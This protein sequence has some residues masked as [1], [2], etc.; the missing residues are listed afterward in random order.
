MNEPDPCCFWCEHLILD[1]L[2]SWCEEPDKQA[3]TKKVCDLYLVNWDRVA[4]CCKEN[5]NE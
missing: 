1:G 4:N 5:I 2:N 3:D